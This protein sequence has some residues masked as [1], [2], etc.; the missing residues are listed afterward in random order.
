MNTTKDIVM[1][2]NLFLTAED[3]PESHLMQDNNPIIGDAKFANPGG[4]TIEDYISQ[5]AE[6]A[7]ST[8][9][10]II[11]LPQDSLGISSVFNADK[12]NGLEVDIDILGNAIEGKT[13]IGAILPTEQVFGPSATLTSMVSESTTQESLLITVSF[14]TAI[15]DLTLYAFTVENGVISGLTQISD[16]QWSFTLMPDQYG[17]TSVKLNADT[18]VDNN[19]N[20]NLAAEFSITF[21]QVTDQSDMTP[22]VAIISGPSGSDTTQA[23]FSLD[24]NFDETVVDFEQTDLIEENATLTNFTKNNDMQW[25]VQVKAS[26]FGNVSVTLPDNV[27]FDIAGNGNEQSTFSINYKN[28]VSPPEVVQKSKSGGSFSLYSLFSLMFLIRNK[29]LTFRTNK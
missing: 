4:L 2:N 25:T 7:T 14:N 24:F 26:A 29:T 21:A 11:K 5:S 16:M 19:E 15:D 27:V 28:T 23:S 22:P 1:S 3:W 9:I 13:F 6:V 10:K 20:G 18:V 17:L 12:I 8:G